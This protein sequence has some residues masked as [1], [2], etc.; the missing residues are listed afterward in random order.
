MDDIWPPRTATG[1][2]RS[3]IWRRVS[4]SVLSAGLIP[5]SMVWPTARTAAVSPRPASDRVIRVWDCES[6]HEL[7]TLRGH[8]D[9]VDLVAFSPDGRLIVSASWD[10][11]LRLWEAAT[12]RPLAT[13]GGHANGV[14]GWLSALTA[15]GLPRSARTG[16]YGSGVQSDVWSLDEDPRRQVSHL[17]CRLQPRRQ[18]SRRVPASTERCTSGRWREQPIKRSRSGVMLT[19]QPQAAGH[20]SEPRFGQSSPPAIASPPNNCHG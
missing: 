15:N 19:V 6:G 16:R 10:Q 12:G 11:T 17:E 20:R 5:Q 8:L 14:W 7:H 4:E 18:A 13:L 1:T 2:S 9:T 3:G